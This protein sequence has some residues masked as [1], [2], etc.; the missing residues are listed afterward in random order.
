MGCSDA[1]ESDAFRNSE[2]FF[3]HALGKIPLSILPKIDSVFRDFVFHELEGYS[4]IASSK[5]RLFEAIFEI[6]FNGDLSLKTTLSLF[7]E[8]RPF[9]TGASLGESL[10]TS[11]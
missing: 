7:H 10:V 5:V 8:I 1:V 2:Y 9:R 3:G 11:V 6:C 4:F